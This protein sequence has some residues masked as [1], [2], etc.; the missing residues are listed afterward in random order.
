MTA[1][2][3]SSKNVDADAVDGKGDVPVSF[4]ASIEMRLA[5][6]EG[7]L[8]EAHRLRKPD[9]RVSDLVRDAVRKHLTEIF[10]RAA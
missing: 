10:D 2:S 4:R 6:R 8:K 7:A 5:M 3:N 1:T 9:Y